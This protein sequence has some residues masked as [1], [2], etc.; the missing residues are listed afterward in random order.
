MKKINE[1]YNCNYSG[2][3]KDIK[4]N[5]K[6]VMPGDAFVCTKGVNTDRHDFIDEA[7]DNGASV[8]IV[9]KDG[10]YKI[11]YIKVSDPNKEL[12]IL[13]SKFYDN[14]DKKIK[15]IGITGTD[16]KTT[17]ATIIRD[18]LGIDNCGY[19]GTNGIIGKTFSDNVSNTTPECHL[20]YKYLYLFLKDGLNYASMETSSEAFYRNRLDSFNFDVGIL[21][22]IT[23]DHLN[24]HK[25]LDNYVESKKQLFRQLKDD[26]I[27][28]LNIDDEYYDSFK[29]INKNVVTYG[30]NPKADL[31]IK[32]VDEKINGTNISFSYNG[33]EYTIT[34]PLLGEFN[35][36]NL[37]ASILCLIHFNFSINDILSRIKNITTPSGRCEVLDFNTNYKIVLDYAHTANGLSSILN[38]L[39]KVKENRI[40]T[41]TGSAGG[42]EKEK[43][44][45]MGKVVLKKSDLVIFTMDDPRYENPKDIIN[46]MIN[47]NN[48]NYKI[49]IDREEAIK[50]ALDNA[51]EG[52]IILIAG[53]G[54]DNYMAIED[55]YVPY[56]DYEVINNYFNIS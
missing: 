16:G 51:K 11:P 54:R 20:I 26:G 29:K 56:S 35:V 3:V 18:L 9:K 49:I 36:Y 41:V 8:L 30:K 55:K 25:T 47:N 38:Y 50:Y 10:N 7:I 52:D 23:G 1:L 31:C 4:I 53:K 48:G 33:E 12:S 14:P 40:I 2:E 24:I 44:K 27:A 5:S 34:S 13:S 43:R 17:T 22:N 37:M 6:E 39:N 32:Q 46:D 28:I 21:T 45:N 19:I 15:L 42:R